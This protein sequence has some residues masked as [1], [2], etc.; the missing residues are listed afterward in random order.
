M[1]LKETLMKNIDSRT[2]QLL[3]LQLLQAAAHL[4]RNNTVHRDLKSENIFVEYD[5]G[6]FVIK[7]LEMFFGLKSIPYLIKLSTRTFYY[8][9][10]WNTF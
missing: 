5:L 3:C 4:E 1:T 10:L 9:R 6:K 7:N 8:F 2:R